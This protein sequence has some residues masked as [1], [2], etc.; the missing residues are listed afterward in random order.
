MK[1]H[2]L[3]NHPLYQ[4]WARMKR[5]CYNKNG[6]KYHRYGGRG[7]RMC[8]QWID[9]PEVFIKWSLD[10]GYSEG[11]TIDRKDND[12]NYSPDNCRWITK[13]DQ[14]YNRSTNVVVTSRGITASISEFSDISKVARSTVSNRIKA[15][16][17]LDDAIWTPILKLRRKYVQNERDI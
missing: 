17:S 6:D 13:K 7:I 16:W 14:A 10:N 3:R 4:T 5:R 2:L 12:G 1:T 11:L 15:G 8:E 9:N